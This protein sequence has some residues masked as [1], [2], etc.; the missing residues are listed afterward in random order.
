MRRSARVGVH[1]G[2]GVAGVTVS[3]GGGRVVDVV[4]VGGASLS[5][6]G[7]G[8]RRVSP[9]LLLSLLLI[10]VAVLVLL[11]GVEPLGGGG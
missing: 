7:W 3:V 5:M 9:L 11:R 2:L 10:L 8:V 6:E 4:V 1:V